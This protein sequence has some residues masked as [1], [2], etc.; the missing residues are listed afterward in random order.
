MPSPGIPDWYPDGTPLAIREQTGACLWPRKH[1]PSADDALVAQESYE[2]IMD[3]IC[4]E[5]GVRLVWARASADG[6][7]PGEP[8]WW[9]WSRAPTTRKEIECWEVTDA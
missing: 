6:E 1:Y 9:R 8:G 4:E 3:C 5:R 2:G 7:V